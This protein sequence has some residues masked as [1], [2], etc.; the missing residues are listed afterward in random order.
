M[1]CFLMNILEI[2]EK[3]KNFITRCDIYCVELNSSDGHM[4]QNQCANF[5]YLAVYIFW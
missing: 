3:Q 1:S 5:W 2:F 4:Q